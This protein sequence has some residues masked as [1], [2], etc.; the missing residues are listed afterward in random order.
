MIQGP[1]SWNWGGTW[2]GACAKT[3]NSN[4]A[5]EFI[6]Y[7]ATDDTFLEQWAK[8]TGDVVSNAKAVDRVKGTFSEPF[9]GGQNHYAEFAEMAK[10]VNGKLS[11]RTDQAIEGIFGEEVDAYVNGEKSKEQALADFKDQVA[12]QFSLGN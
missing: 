12:A 3:K 11:Q 7:I 4:A 5:K 1:A 2:I 9:L 10:N 6:R 8:D